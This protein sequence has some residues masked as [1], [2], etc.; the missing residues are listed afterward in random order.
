MLASILALV[1]REKA[2]RE[3]IEL[4]E[5]QGICDRLDLLADDLATSKPFAA[6]LVMRTVT[7]LEELSAE[8]ASSR[9]LPNPRELEQ[10]LSEARLA[11]S[12][13]YYELE[14]AREDLRVAQEAL[15]IQR[16]GFG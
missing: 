12:Q 1:G 15:L 5:I 7:V 2:K 13:T 9:T 16:Q 14:Q 4:R 3:M 6:L 8:V 10:K 11:A